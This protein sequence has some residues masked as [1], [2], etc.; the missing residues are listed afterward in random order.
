MSAPMNN[1][2]DHQ[3]KQFEG[4]KT[5]YKRINLKKGYKSKAVNPRSTKNTRFFKKGEFSR[6]SHKLEK[7]CE[8]VGKD[9]L[10]GPQ[11]SEYMAKR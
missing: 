4:K 8:G 7:F 11:T 1:G 3:L 6:Y 2:V 10:D 5:N 9:G